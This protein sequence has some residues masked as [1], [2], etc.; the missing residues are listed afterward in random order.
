[1]DFLSPDGTWKVTTGPKA[2]IIN[3]ENG[4]SKDLSLPNIEWG[5]WRSDSLCFF[6]V[7]RDERLYYIDVFGE[8]L[9]LID[10]DVADPD[11]IEFMWTWLE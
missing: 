6:A 7:T 10:D 4:A 2:A 8:Q 9:K 5:T 3:M 11:W 1:M